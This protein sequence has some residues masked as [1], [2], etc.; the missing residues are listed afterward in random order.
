MKKI[1]TLFMVSA[2]A[3]TTRAQLVFNENFSGYTNGNLG[4]QGSWIQNGTGTD[5]QVNNASPLIYSGY[6]SGTQYITTSST[7]GTD[8]N[9]LFIGG[10][11]I[12]TGA[13]ANQF[14]YISF[15]VRVTSIATANNS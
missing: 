5:V 12:P 7:D 1:Y 13:T 14:I 8:P 6:Q 2:I 3:L 4:A 9:K 11:T 10:A 15:V